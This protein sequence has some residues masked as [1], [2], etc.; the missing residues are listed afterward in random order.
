VERGACLTDGRGTLARLTDTGYG[1]LHGAAPGH[2][3]G[4]RAHLFDQLSDTQVGQLNRIS[5]AVGAHLLEV[6]AAEG[7][8]E[9]P[10]PPLRRPGS[11]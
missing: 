8:A 10:A 5:D 2:V 4:V 6:D 7:E 1:V 9:A 11:K 3:A